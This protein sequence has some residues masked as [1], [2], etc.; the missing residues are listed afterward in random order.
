MEGCVVF[1]WRWLGR[2]PSLAWLFRFCFAGMDVGGSASLGEGR[3]SFCACCAFC[4]ALLLAGLASFPW[5]RWWAGRCIVGSAVLSGCPWGS[6]FVCL[7]GVYVPMLT[8]SLHL[9]GP[10]IL[11]R[12]FLVGGLSVGVE[13]V[14]LPRL[15]GCGC[16]P[17]RPSGEWALFWLCPIGLGR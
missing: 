1:L 5:A 15:P 7:W 14:L 2:N 17:C 11:G 8:R 3:H 9:G 6:Q 10:A 4:A 16:G 13:R 12:V